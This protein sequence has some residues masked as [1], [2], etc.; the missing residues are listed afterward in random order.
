MI[1]CSVAGMPYP[2]KLGKLRLEDPEFK[3]SLGC[4]E[5]LRTSWSTVETRPHPSWPSGATFISTGLMLSGPHSTEALQ[6]LVWFL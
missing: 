2:P 1:Q 5:S 3:D 6:F 4:M